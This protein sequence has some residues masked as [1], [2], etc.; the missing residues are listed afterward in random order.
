M[1]KTAAANLKSV[2][3]T[4]CSEGGIGFALAKAFQARGLHVIATARSL[5][6]MAALSKLP[7]VTLVSLDVCSPA[8]LDAAV[9]SVSATTGGKLDY[10][11]NN[12]GSQYV[13]PVLDADLQ[14]AKDMFEVNVWGVVATVKAFAPLLIAAKGTVVNNASI[15]GLMYPPYMVLYSASK[16]ATLT[17][18]EGLRL[19][20]KPLGVK[21]VTLVTGAVGTNLFTNAPEHHLPE[22]SRYAAAENEIAARATGTD[23]GD[24]VMPADEYARSVVS[25]V[26]SGSTGRIFRGKMASMVRMVTTLFPTSMIDMMTTQNT[27]LEKVKP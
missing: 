21:V 6:K 8:S 22:G 12:S 17:I 15:A 11:V 3:I 14:K 26:L 5:S 4:G 27:G 2:L 20:L 25:D 18:S 1:S 10:L 19:E 23:V 16:A 9:A 24:N 7:N 13:M